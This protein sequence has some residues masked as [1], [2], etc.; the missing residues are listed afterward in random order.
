LNISRKNDRRDTFAAQLRQWQTKFIALRDDKDPRKVV[1]E[2][3]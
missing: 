2:G 1:K 3:D